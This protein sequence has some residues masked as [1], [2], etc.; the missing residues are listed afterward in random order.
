M[1]LSINYFLLIAE[2]ALKNKASLDSYLE[3]YDGLCSLRKV[4]DYKLY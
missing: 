1:V 2:A 4:S 3:V